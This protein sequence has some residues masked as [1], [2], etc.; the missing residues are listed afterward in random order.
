MT[1]PKLS[2][3]IYFFQNPPGLKIAVL[4]FHEI[5]HDCTNPECDD[6]VRVGCGYLNKT[7]IK[8]R[9][10]NLFEAANSC[11]V[12]AHPPSLLHVHLSPKHYMRESV[13]GA[14]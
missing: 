14:K 4:K 9:V 6:R 5:F 8:V 11:D 2:G 10:D 12:L 7:K 1:F 3:F 13:G